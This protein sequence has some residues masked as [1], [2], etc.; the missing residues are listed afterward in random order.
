MDLIKLNIGGTLF[1][2]SRETLLKVPNSKLASI[3]DSERNFNTELGAHYFDRRPD[4]FN[5][6]LQACR[7]GVLHIPSNTCGDDIWAEMEF[8]NLPKTMI[9][10]CC[11]GRMAAAEAEKR[12]EETVRKEILGDFEKSIATYKESVGWKKSAAKLWI[13]RNPGKNGSLTLV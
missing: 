1:V 11:V 13:M 12:V 8:W 9:A 5:A 10:P 4:L 7:E 2:T 3:L 6:I